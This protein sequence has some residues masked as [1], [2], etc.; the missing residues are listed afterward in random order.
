MI[1]I[2]TS[3]ISKRKLRPFDAANRDDFSM[4]NKLP[5]YRDTDLCTPEMITIVSGNVIKYFQY[6]VKDTY[7]LSGI[8]NLALLKIK[9]YEKR[10][11]KRLEP[12]QK[13]DPIEEDLTLTIEEDET[14]SM[15]K[16]ETSVPEIKAPEKKRLDY[17][18]LDFE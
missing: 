6:N 7:A 9:E 11:S 10:E 4:Y 5:Y 13:K 16:S 17:L 2:E 18:D 8:D 12:F 3:R 15:D 1:I 14:I